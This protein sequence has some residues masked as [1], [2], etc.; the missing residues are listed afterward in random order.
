MRV[1]KDEQNG[2]VRYDNRTFVSLAGLCDPD[3]AWI[4][5]DLFADA[6]NESVPPGSE[7][8]ESEPCDGD[9]SGGSDGGTHKLCYGTRYWERYEE[10]MDR[11]LNEELQLGA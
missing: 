2:A 9:A 11:R 8:Y 4:D 3:H 6:G 5:N 10:T 7:A 1:W